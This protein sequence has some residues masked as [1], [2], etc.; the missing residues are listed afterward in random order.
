ML[1]ETEI[2]DYSGIEMRLFSR[3]TKKDRENEIK[4][5]ASDLLNS[6]ELHYKIFTCIDGIHFKAR[7]ERPPR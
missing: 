3:K 7:K 2:S 4:N 1:G 5:D 6:S